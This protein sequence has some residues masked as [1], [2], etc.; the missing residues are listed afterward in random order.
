[1]QVAPQSVA[2]QVGE[3]RPKEQVRPVPQTAPQVP[4]LA[5]S[6]RVSM[7]VAP[8]RMAPAGQLVPLTHAPP[9]QL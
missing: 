3:Q 5:G 9:T 2:E 6:D 1:M 4:Q 7:Q 8:H